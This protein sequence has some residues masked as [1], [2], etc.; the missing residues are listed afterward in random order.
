M[1]KARTKADSSMGDEGKSD[2]KLLTV[3]IL[4]PLR[5]LAA[6]GPRQASGGVTVLGS[7]LGASRC[8]CTTTSRKHII[9]SQ[10]IFRNHI[11]DLAHGVGKFSLACFLDLLLQFL[12]LLQ[13]F[14]LRAHGVRLE[15]GLRAF[16]IKT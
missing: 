11:A 9:S 8:T 6:A 16:I 14:L 13:Q 7:H 3:L 1:K 5:R 12:S 2:D 4:N 15:S 10:A